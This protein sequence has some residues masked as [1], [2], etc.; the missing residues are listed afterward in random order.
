MIRNALINRKNW[1][2]IA[3]ID[4][5]K[6]AT[7]GE[8]AKKALSI[9]KMLLKEDAQNIAVFLPD[10]ADFIAAFFGVLMSNKAVFPL[11][12]QLSKYE[13]LPLIHKAGVHTIVTSQAN[14]DLFENMASEYGLNLD[15][16]YLEELNTENLEL[17]TVE[18]NDKG[19]PEQP[20]ILLSTSGTTGNAKIVQLSEINFETSTFGY[21][22][23]MDY[24]K[25][26]DMD[27][28]YV[29][30][31]PFCSAYGLLVVAV[32]ILRS[33]P[34]VVVEGVFT[35]NSLYKAAQD[36]RATHYEG[37]VMTAVMMD[38]TS[39]R[40]IVYDISSL[41]YL[42]LAG[43]KISSQILA[44]LLKS[45]PDI[46]FWTGYG[47]TEAAPLIAKPYKRMPANKLN[48]VGL[49]YGNE[50][51]MIEDKGEITDLPFQIGEIVVKGENVMIGYLD[52]EEET[53]KVIKN[54]F[55][56]TGD[57]G[58]LDEEGYL[59]IC[60]RKKNVIIVRGFNVYPEEVESCLMN[61][62]LVKDCV[63]Y[64]EVDDDGEEFVCADVVLSGS[65]VSEADIR[66]FLSTKLTN[67]KLPKKI[68]IREILQKTATGK[69]KIV[70][71]T[72]E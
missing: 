43:S 31:T 65:E 55:L 51:I 47:M 58:Y 6:T 46:E 16:I 66:D 53:A 70:K 15:I 50:I 54:G 29:I 39:D 30:G 18:G 1:D 67:Y 22:G 8:L 62:K 57:I 9:Q 21:I 60:G 3:I 36:Y 11:N 49:A 41:K 61:S 28:R 71:G 56:Y 35:L 42:G 12:S 45:F 69:N 33:F 4:S 68:Y 52:N 44:R 64:G 34:I 72:D 40:E 59:Y 23:N 25:C 37:G 26:R 63:V 2:D 20:M 14:R 48:S 32:C 13:L 19:K 27:I 7:Y 24:D 38:Q 17:D 5:G 10:G